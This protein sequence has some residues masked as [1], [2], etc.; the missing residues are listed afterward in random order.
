MKKA[1]LAAVVALAGFAVVGTTSYTNDLQPPG[2]RTGAPSEN[3]CATSN[4]HAGT[5]NSGQGSITLT[6]SNPALKY[7]PGDTFQITV[8]VSDPTKT[9]WGFELTALNATNDSTPGKFLNEATG[10]LVSYPSPIS[11]L[12]KRKYVAH[13]DANTSTSQWVIN[14]VA[15]ATDVGKICFYA[16][17]N[18]S[19]NSGNT[20]GDN[21]YTASL[22]IE[23]ESSVGLTAYP[24]MPL[25]FQIEGIRFRQIDV[26]YFLAQPT[27]VRWVLYDLSGRMLQVFSDQQEQAGNHRRQLLLPAGLAEG[28]YLLQFST[29]AQQHSVKFYYR[30]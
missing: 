22:C 16:A 19:N 8:K 28:L 30:P 2:S 14:W 29:D 4:C 15:P 1:I 12:P 13:R 23:P 20:S 24:S 5:V 3:T 17:G 9:K 21:I 10:I 18:A 7:I 27:A 11:S 25:S 26:S 6:F